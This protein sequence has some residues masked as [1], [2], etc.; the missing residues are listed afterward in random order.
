MCQETSLQYN[1]Q[2]WSGY[3]IVFMVT[4][5]PPESMRVTHDLR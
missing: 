4:Q 1:T 5:I 3:W 2:N